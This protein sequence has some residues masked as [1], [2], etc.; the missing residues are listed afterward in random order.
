[1]QQS[2]G[3][4]MAQQPFM[5]AVTQ[6]QNSHSKDACAGV[7]SFLGDYWFSLPYLSATGAIFQAQLLSVVLAFLS[8][9]LA[10][11]LQGRSLYR[12]IIKGGQ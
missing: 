3:S 7:A 11:R 10:P 9:S 2:P 8:S 5:A 1:M 4:H 6:L 12:P